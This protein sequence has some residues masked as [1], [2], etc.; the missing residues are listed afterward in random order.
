M[1]RVRI[2]CFSLATVPYR[3]FLAGLPDGVAIGEIEPDD[4]C[5]LSHIDPIRLDTTNDLGL[6]IG[7]MVFIAGW[8]RTQTPPEILGNDDPCRAIDPMFEARSLHVGISTLNAS[9]CALGGRGGSIKFATDNC[10]TTALV[11]CHDSGG[12]LL[13]EVPGGQLRLIGVLYTSGSAY[14][15]QRH[16]LISS[17]ADVTFFCRPCRPP[18]CGDIDGDSGQLQDCDD[19]DCLE[20]L[21]E[22]ATRSCLTDQEV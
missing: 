8:G 18:A 20:A 16:Q 7:Q 15:A 6:C 13:V 19:H 4:L 3:E 12:G 11:Q 17:P 22:W 5:Y 2:N 14:M 21:G 9:D 1:I 10:Q